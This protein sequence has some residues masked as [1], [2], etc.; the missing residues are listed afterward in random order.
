MVV[1]TKVVTAAAEIVAV[2]AV[3]VVAAVVVAAARVTEVVAEVTNAIKTAADQG[4]ANAHLGS[5]R[6]DMTPSKTKRQ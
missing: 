3:I 6:P 1:V 5:R 2:V 4:R